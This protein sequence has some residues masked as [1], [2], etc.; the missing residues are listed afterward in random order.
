MTAGG[1]VAWRVR[2]A[3]DPEQPGITLA[4]LVAAGTGVFAE[5]NAV[6][7]LRLSDGRTLWRRAFSKS[8]SALAGAVYGLW[9]WRGN[10][11]VLVGQVTSAARLVSLNGATG[12]VRWTRALGGRGLLGDQTT[13]S[14][15]VLAMLTPGGILE[16]ADLNTGKILWSRK[17]GT[18]LGPAASG[19]IIAAGSNGRAIGYDSRTGRVLWTARGLPPQTDLTEADGLFLAWSNA[20][21]PGQ[22]TAVTALNPR[23]GRTAWRFDPGTPVTILGAG[24]AGVA[25]ATYVPRRRLYLVNPATGQTRWSVAAFPAAQG[26][27]PGQLAETKAYV[28]LAEG[29]VAAPP[30]GFRLAVRR[31]ATGRVVWSVPL[32]AGGAPGAQLALVPLASGPLLAVAG[33][34]RAST[35]SRLA[36]YRLASGRMVGSASLPTLV[37]AP[38]AVAG[39]SVLAQLDSPG[40]AIPASSGSATAVVHR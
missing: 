1:R 35:F 34:D 14:N 19:T 27:F 9:Q 33:A 6:Y 20:A 26:G 2:L 25:L 8:A 3:T 12:A 29:S 22:P 37:Q 4:P 28:V 17:N 16:A 38:L 40:C 21:G 30:A 15:G 13:T 31:A 23:T 7:A 11:S 24:P 5:E 10:V 18:S 32:P 39:T 36:L